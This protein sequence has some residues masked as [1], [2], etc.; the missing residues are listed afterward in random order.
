MEENEI[1]KEDMEH[2]LENL[3]IEWNEK[4]NTITS[5]LDSIDSN[6][7]DINDNIEEYLVISKPEKQEEE[8]QEEEK[9]EKKEET[10]GDTKS[11][12]QTSEEYLEEILEIQQND[13]ITLSNIENL[14]IVNVFSIGILI[15]VMLLT[16]FWNRYFK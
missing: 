6:V 15:G 10:K 5:S 4:T 9:E 3:R 14:L 13:S 11:T 2:A 7:Q 8:K 16:L 1:T 12:F